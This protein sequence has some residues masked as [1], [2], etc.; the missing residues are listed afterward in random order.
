MSPLQGGA[1]TPCFPS[2]APFPTWQ[3]RRLLGSTQHLTSP[4][5]WDKPTGEKEEE[6]PRASL[7]RGPPLVKHPLYS[8]S[9]S[10][11]PGWCR[12]LPDGRSWARTL[13]LPVLGEGLRV[14]LRAGLRGSVRGCGAPVLPQPSSAGSA[15]LLQPEG[16]PFAAAG[17]PPRGTPPVLSSGTSTGSVVYSSSL[18]E[19]Q[20]SV[21]IEWKQRQEGL[22]GLTYEET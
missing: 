14:G 2:P 1:L 10:Q 17:L 4:Y 13:A 7:S 12:R 8:L 9:C 6:A 18:K 16:G 21:K 22:E 5:S 15:C 11:C 19:K 20:K 3:L